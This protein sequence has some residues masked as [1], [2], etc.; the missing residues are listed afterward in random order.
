MAFTIRRTIMRRSRGTCISCRRHRLRTYITIRRIIGIT[1]LRRPRR[2]I[3]MP[4]IT[5]TTIIADRAE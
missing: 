2:G 1:T 3:I 5:I 4:R